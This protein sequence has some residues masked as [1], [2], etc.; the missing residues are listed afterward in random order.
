[1]AMSLSLGSKPFTTTSPIFN[2]PADISSRPAIIL[3]VVDFP[4]PEGPTNTINS[5]SSIC[6]LKSFTALVPLGYTL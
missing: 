2:S 1:M 5:L 3:K 4:Q 6:I